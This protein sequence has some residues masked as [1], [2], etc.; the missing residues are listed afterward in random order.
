[1]QKPRIIAM[2]GLSRPLH[3]RG[4]R[5]L[6]RGRYPARA[7]GVVRCSPNSEMSAPDDE[8][9]VAGA[10]DHDD[11]D[12]RVGIAARAACR[13]APARISVDSALRLAGLLNVRMATAADHLDE[14]QFGARARRCRRVRSVM[15]VLSVLVRQPDVSDHAVARG[16]ARCPRAGSRAPRALRRCARPSRA[17]RADGWRRRRSSGPR[18]DEIQRS[19]DGCS[20]CSVM[21]GARPADRRIPGPSC[22]PARTGTPAALSAATHS[23]VPRVR[24]RAPIS[25]VQ[26]GP[27]RR[28]LGRR[29]EPRVVRQPGR[30][31]TSQ[32]LPAA[33]RPARADVDVAVGGGEAAHRDARRVMVP[34]WLGH[35]AVDGPPGG[36]EVHHRDHRFQQRRLHPAAAPGPL[37]LVQRDE[38][39]DRQVQ[40]GGQVGHRDPGPG[41][42]RCR[43]AR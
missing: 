17:R 5:R 11:P 34:A 43:A 2:T 18:S 16:A 22:R 24:S 1:M 37:P 33:G 26:L 4:H 36:L 3:A 15:R 42:A 21:R 30:P 13:A 32:R 9:L 12:L 41:R 35:L 38:H 39:A 14:Q 19:E 31:M 6:T 29:V 28:A 20:T 25:V 40:A 23:A 7:S 8:G 27:V 10:G